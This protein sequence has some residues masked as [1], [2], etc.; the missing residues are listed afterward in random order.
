ILPDCVP[1]RVAAKELQCHFVKVTEVFL[2][3]LVKTVCLKAVLRD[4]EVI[5]QFLL[6]RLV[7]VGDAEVLVPVQIRVH[8]PAGCG[9]ENRPPDV[10]LD[11][12]REMEMKGSYLGIRTGVRK[13][14]RVPRAAAA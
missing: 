13:V 12:P 11:Q 2:A 1:D 14:N 6:E 9:A 3:E 10:G 8:P 5:R 7:L 4:Q